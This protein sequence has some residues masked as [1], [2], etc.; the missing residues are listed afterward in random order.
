V[1]ANQ[2]LKKFADITSFPNVMEAF[3]FGDGLLHADMNKKVKMKGRWSSHFFG[4]GHPLCLE[5]ACGKGEYTI[6]LAGLYPARNFIG[7]D[8]KGT[9]IWKGARQAFERNMQNVGFLRSRIEFIDTYFDKGEVAEIW[10]VFPD[11]FL[12]PRD[13]NRRL[14]AQPFLDRYLHVLEN[15]A[16][17]HLKTDSDELYEFTLDSIDQHANYQIEFHEADIDRS[18]RSEELAIKSFYEKQHLKN[19]KKIKYIRARLY[20]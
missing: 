13:E 12:K 11:P 1:P 15:G 10:I 2:K 17:L 16:N 4:N 18:P 20:K 19:H 3:T 7:M 5:L 8:V 6:G 14:T 9:R